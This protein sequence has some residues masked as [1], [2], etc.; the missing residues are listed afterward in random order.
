[1]E[2]ESPKLLGNLCQCS[3]TVNSK[4]CFSVL[5]GSLLCFS[6]CQLP[7]VLSL[8]TTEK[9]MALSFLHP[10]FRY[11]HSLMRCPL[12]LCPGWTVHH[13]SLFP[14]EE[15]LQFLNYFKSLCWNLSSWSLILET[16]SGHTNAIETWT[17]CITNKG[18][19]FYV[20]WNIFI[21]TEHLNQ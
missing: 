20:G 6:L 1:M 19:P 5:R 12:A 18:F 10:P 3:L 15:M 17:R 13:N 14:M 16:R 9:S 2:T 8:D 4:K 11:L 7:L 21:F